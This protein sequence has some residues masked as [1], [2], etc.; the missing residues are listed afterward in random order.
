MMFSTMPPSLQVRSVLL[1]TVLDGESPIQKR[2]AAYLVLMKNPEPSDL[3]Q[4]LSAL[5][6]EQ[7]PQAKSFV[8]S[9]IA[10]IMSSTNPA[11]L[12]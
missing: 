3:A 11:S 8:A 6:N 5:P 9:H 12:P 4:V 2:V 1:Q 7:D 10:N